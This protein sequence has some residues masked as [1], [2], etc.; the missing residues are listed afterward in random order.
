MILS[1]R[2][3]KVDYVTLVVVEPDH[4]PTVYH[5]RDLV[6]KTVRQAMNRLR[7]DFCYIA[8]PIKLNGARVLVKSMRVLKK[9]D[10]LTVD[11]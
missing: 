1:A 10:K 6:G 7:H 8:P 2:G 11:P 9:G 5:R 3:K 4:P